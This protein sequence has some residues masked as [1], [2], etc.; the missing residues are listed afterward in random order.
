MRICIPSQ[1]NRGALSEVC[2]HFGSAPY[3]TLYDSEQDAF[4][5]LSN[6]NSQ[7]QHGACQPMSHLQGRG[8]DCVACRGLGLRA[9]E[10]LR[11]SGISVFK[12]DC[13]T[14]GEVV[15]NLSENT[16]EPM[17]PE[18]ACQDHRCH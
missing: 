16:L 11:G 5:I 9:L 7:H 14:V 13:A 10:K 8:I 15:R 17:D 6:G 3:F 4:E 12:T 1:D 2:D 18:A